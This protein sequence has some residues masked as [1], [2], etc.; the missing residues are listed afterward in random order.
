MKFLASL[1]LAALALALV[2]DARACD[3]AAAF[4]F[5]PHQNYVAPATSFG[6]ALPAAPATCPTMNT[7][8]AQQSYAAPSSSL[9]NV[10]S[11]LQTAG[12][13]P[14]ALLQSYGAGAFGAG[15]YGAGVA[16]YGS[17]FGAFG[18][19]G[20]GNGFGNGFFGRRSF[21]PGARGVPGVHPG[22]HPGFHG[23]R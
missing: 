19:Q 13:D 11:I 12:F 15:G 17:G 14:S 16:G 21:F 20:Y 7:F 4:R 23:H 6:L 5:A 8:A 10:L 3:P 22:F 1:T 2:P 9:A 18:S